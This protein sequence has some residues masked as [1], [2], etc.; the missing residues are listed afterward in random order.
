[1][2]Y[3]IKDTQGNTI[4]ISTY[5]PAHRKSYLKRKEKI[6][7]DIMS[8]RKKNVNKTKSRDTRKGKKA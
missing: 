3:T 1:M 4:E 5:T 8:K 2:V 7:K 6:I